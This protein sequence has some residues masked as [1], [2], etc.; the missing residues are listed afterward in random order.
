[1]KISFFKTYKSINSNSSNVTKT[2]KFEFQVPKALSHSKESEKPSNLKMAFGTKLIQRLDANRSKLK[3][4]NSKANLQIKK[5]LETLLGSNDSLEDS[6][7]TKTLDKIPLKRYSSEDT[8]ALK[9]YELNILKYVGNHK[10][11]YGK[12]RGFNN[13]SLRK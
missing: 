7:I 2:Q 13:I 4:S 6:K 9:D 5:R 8:K 11:P 10:D 12:I 3:K 1:M